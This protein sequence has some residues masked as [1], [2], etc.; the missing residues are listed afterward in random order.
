MT[1]KLIV[2]AC[3]MSDGPAFIVKG[4]FAW[5]L[6]ELHR[7]GSR[8]C[9]PLDNPGPRWSAYVHFLRHEHG[10]AIETVNESHSGPFPGTH[11]RYVL[12]SRVAILSRSEEPEG[13][14]A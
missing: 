1:A 2:T 8:G 3:L 13:R 14:P 6:L 4:R 12:K 11:G 7:A 10:L 5:A 9:T